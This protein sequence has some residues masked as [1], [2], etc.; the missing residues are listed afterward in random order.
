M[1]ITLDH[2]FICC[3][4]GGPEA[5]ALVALGLTEGSGNVHPGQG[6]ANRRFFFDGGF[7]ELL[8]VHNAGEAQSALTAPTRLWERWAGRHTN[9]CRFGVAFS[10]GDDQVPEPPFAAWPYRPAYLPLDKSIW[11]AQHTSLREPELFYMAW[12]HP[13]ATAVGQRREHPAGLVRWLGASVGLPASTALSP[14]SLAVHSAG[15]LGF[16]TSAEPELVLTFDAPH[17]VVLDLRTSLGL[18]L[19]GAPQPG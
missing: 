15:L 9:A 4:P 5:E 18:L 17:D 10:P 8:W 13:Q 2:V 7:I 16:H 19:Q 12:P 14:A 1:P 3:D 6:T 11:F